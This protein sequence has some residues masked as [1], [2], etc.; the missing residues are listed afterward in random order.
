MPTHRRIQ[1][2]CWWNKEHFGGKMRTTLCI[3]CI[4]NVR[5]FR[6]WVATT[7]PLQTWKRCKYVDEQENLSL[8]IMSGK[9]TNGQKVQWDYS[10]RHAQQLMSLTHLKASTLTGQNAD[11]Y[12]TV[13][14]SILHQLFLNRR[15]CE[16]DL[17]KKMGGRKFNDSGEWARLIYFLFSGLK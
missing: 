6:I 10:K 14:S 3:E 15:L 1:P 2:I 8:W 4:S 13:E 17:W 11:E 7:Q 12:N 16:D 9:T 5:A